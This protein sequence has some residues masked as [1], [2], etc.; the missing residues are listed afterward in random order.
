MRQ[1]RVLVVEDDPDTSDLLVKILQAAGHEV[2][3]TA[4]GIDA[5]ALARALKPDLV[6][7]DLSLPDADGTDVCREL[8]EFSDAYVM[9][10]TARDDQVD[11]L[12]GLHLG[13]DDYLVKPIS[14]LELRA[15]SE[16]L[17]RRPRAAR[18][19]EV[20]IDA[21]G[22]L[23]L[24][25]SAHAATLSGV[26]LPLTS[27]EVDLLCVLSRTPRRAWTRDELGTEV[28]GAGFS[29][30]DYL[31]DIHVGSVR[32]KLRR[33]GSAREWIATIDGQAYELVPDRDTPA[34]TS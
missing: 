23:L 15:R 3:S 2:T 27:A 17:L 19:P 11:R 24:S 22:G 4:S 12:I 28:W 26:P 9:M 20:A 34:P 29:Q 14:P 21:G 6:T 5:L 31:V 30:S 18:E 8:R 16:A 25:P 33:S 13:A 32:R 7:L 10:V 1:T